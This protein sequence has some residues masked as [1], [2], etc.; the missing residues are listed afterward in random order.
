MLDLL[1]GVLGIYAAVFWWLGLYRGLWR[2][3]SL[4]DLQ[5][6]V[7]AVG[8]G[9]AR[10]TRR[11]LLLTQLSTSVP[12]TVY[13]LT[14]VLLMLLM[15]GSRLAYRAW[16]EGR[17]LPLIAKPQ[18]TP[19]LVLGAG[20][21]AAGAAAG[22]G[23]QPAVARRGHAGRRRAASRAARSSGVKVLGGIERVGDIA[24]ELGVSQAVIAMPSATHQERQRALDL[25]AQA[26]ICR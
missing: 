11:L 9:G 19:V 22:P 1:P 21:T 2:Y 3:A 26:R 13:V 5:R 24:E 7:I 4:P 23:R 18:A 12:R 6:I 14:P 25:C 16:R 20:A 10:G 15:G 17:L 8:I